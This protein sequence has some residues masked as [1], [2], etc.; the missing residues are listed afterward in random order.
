M[1]ILK[2]SQPDY[3]ARS[4]KEALTSSGGGSFEE[5]GKESVEPDPQAVDDQSVAQQAAA[6]LNPYA[7]TSSLWF[8][9]L[10]TSLICLFCSLS[11]CRCLCVASIRLF[12][13]KLC[14]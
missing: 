4:H 14:I 13:H 12:S 3:E 8:A 1:E 11:L 10:A 7:R 6:M 2:R 5:T 9:A